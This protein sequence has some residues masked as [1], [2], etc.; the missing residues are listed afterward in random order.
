MIKK[1]ILIVE[2]DMPTID[3]YRMVFKQAKLGI[4]I[5]MFGGDAIERIKKIKEGKAKK[6]DLVLLDLILPDMNGIQ[7]LEEMKKYEETKNIPVFILTNYTNRELEKLGY[8]LKT[9]RYL[10]KTDF[11]PKQIVGLVNE[12]LGK[13]KE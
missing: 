2:D 8:N 13:N 1:T 3:V 6:P 5:I 4:D 9:E 10:L 7:I 11:T 12:R